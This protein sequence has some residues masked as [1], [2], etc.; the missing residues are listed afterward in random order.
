MIEDRKEGDENI[1]WI[2]WLQPQECQQRLTAYWGKKMDSPLK[3][4]E[5]TNPADTMLPAL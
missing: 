4:L 3:P 1:E 5:G 2:M